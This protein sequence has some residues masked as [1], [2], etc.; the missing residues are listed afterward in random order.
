MGDTV[1]RPLL[2]ES[3]R[4]TRAHF[5]ILG[6]SW[7]GWLFDFYDLMLFSFLLIPIKKSLGLDEV[8]LSLLLGASLAATA[9]GGIL[10]GYLADRFGRKSVLS[11]TILVYSLGTFLCGTA[12][13]FAALL[14]FRIVTGL[15]VGGEWAAGQTPVGETFPARVG[16]RA[17]PP[18]DRG[19]G[20]GRR[21]A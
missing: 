2:N 17:A 18:S 7:A 5:I 14:A 21:R 4:P 11:W 1:R 15:G 9:A 6:M 19:R 8:S 20:R 3:G 12:G 16:A 13:S 10:F